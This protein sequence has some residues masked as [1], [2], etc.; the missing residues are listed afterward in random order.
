MHRSISRIA[1]PSGPSLSLPSLH[2]PL[3]GRGGQMG[4]PLSLSFPSPIYLL[5]PH[6]NPQIDVAS[7]SLSLCGQTK[8]ALNYLRIR[9]PSPFRSFEAA[10]LLLMLKLK[11]VTEH[12][13]HSSSAVQEEGRLAWLVGPHSPSD[14]DV[15][16]FPPSCYLSTV[17][18]AHNANM[19]ACMNDHMIMASVSITKRWVLAV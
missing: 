14:G 2:S 3:G 10:N 13:S 11:N 17:I 18:L 5:A 6:P 16:F 9:H 1:F 12:C 4:L 15:A 19:Y 8:L 7:H